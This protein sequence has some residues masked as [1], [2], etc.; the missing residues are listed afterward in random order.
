MPFCFQVLYG[1]SLSVFVQARQ[2]ITIQTKG[3]VPDFF[4]NYMD[5]LARMF[6]GMSFVNE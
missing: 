6:P 3:F 5:L 4:L 2:K 1:F